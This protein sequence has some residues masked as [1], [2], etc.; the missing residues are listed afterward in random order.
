MITNTQLHELLKRSDARKARKAALRAWLDPHHPR[1]TALLGILLVV[2]ALANLWAF[3]RCK[4]PVEY[5]LPESS[6]LAAG[7]RAF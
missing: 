7:V 3:S 5:V 1:H 6:H 4:A 2:L